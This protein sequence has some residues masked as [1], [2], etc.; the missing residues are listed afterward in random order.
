M[1]ETKQVEEVK[2][3]AKG[4]LDLSISDSSDESSDEDT[5]SSTA[6]S[7]DKG[8]DHAND[9][10]A[11]GKKKLS[12]I[13]KK[14]KGLA[15]RAAGS[16]LG[17]SLFQKH[18]DKETQSLIASVCEIIAKEKGSKQAK[19]VKQE[20]LKVA[21]KILLLYQEKTITEESFDTLKFSFRRICSSVRNAYHAKS[22]NEATG[23][24]I[25][26]MATIFYQHLQSS[27]KG[28]V[29]DKTMTRIQT[30]L[31]YVFDPA[32]LVAATQY[33]KE[34]QQ[35]AMVLALYLETSSSS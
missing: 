24:R 12:W 17:A 3:P 5:G 10:V 13:Q 4:I 28:L 18:V 15:S 6:S 8:A 29:S 23:V 20:I 1:E 7:S 19:N 27:I 9:G 2:E 31:D 14:K 16:S 34:F 26:G 21:V 30:L 25:H 22:L 32:L 33:D 11:S 35:I